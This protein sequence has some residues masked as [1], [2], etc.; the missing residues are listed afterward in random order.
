MAPA[1]AGRAP[2]PYTAS[3]GKAAS[4]IRASL[5]DSIAVKKLASAKRG[6]CTGRLAVGTPSTAAVRSLPAVSGPHGA[7]MRGFMK[8]LKKF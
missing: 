4:C 5:P 2:V 3:V 1:I 6:Y 7:W 8:L